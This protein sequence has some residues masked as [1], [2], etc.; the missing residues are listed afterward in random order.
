MSI[1]AQNNEIIPTPENGKAQIKVE[2][3]KPRFLPK[4]KKAE[5]E[6]ISI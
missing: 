1:Q 4:K 2:Y 3:E 5:V 6:L